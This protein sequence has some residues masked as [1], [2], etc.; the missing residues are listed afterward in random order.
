MTKKIEWELR[1]RWYRGMGEACFKRHT[2][3]MAGSWLDKIGQHDD[4]VEE[5]QKWFQ[6]A[7]LAG[8]HIRSW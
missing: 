5:A 6:K 2:S 7:T 8:K 4:G 1:E 3:F